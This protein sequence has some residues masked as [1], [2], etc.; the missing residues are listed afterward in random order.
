MASRGFLKI[1]LRRRSTLAGGTT[2]FKYFAITLEPIS[3][4]TSNSA[5]PGHGRR[6]NHKLITCNLQTSLRA[7]QR[8]RLMLPRTMTSG[9]AIDAQAQAPT[10]IT[11]LS[12]Q[13]RA[14]LRAVCAQ[15]I[16]YPIEEN[17]VDFYWGVF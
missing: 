17:L 6:Q 10:V 7:L 1:R 3:L 8:E 12:L 13:G 2:F 14:K 9:F 15:H 11:W 16:N 5:K 4:P